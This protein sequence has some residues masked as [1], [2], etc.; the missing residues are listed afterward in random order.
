MLLLASLRPDVHTS[1]FQLMLTASGLRSGV[2]ERVD[3]LIPMLPYARSDRTEVASAAIGRDVFLAAIVGAGVDRVW[4][5]DAHIS[6]QQQTPPHLVSLPTYEILTAAVLRYHPT[7]QTIVLP[8]RGAADRLGLGVVGT[9]VIVLDKQRLSDS[10]VEV[11]PHSD[12]TPSGLTVIIDDALFTGA[13]HAA[14]ATLVRR[15][16]SGDVH[17]AVTHALPDGGAMA[18]LERAGVKSVL[19]LGTSS[20]PVAHA[21]LTIRLVRWSEQ[22]GIRSATA[23]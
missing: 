11:S 9:R 3:L 12:T 21:H 18:R 4:T 2:W 8:D 10:E 23:G 13:T 1:L 6:T 7:V 15:L 5:L 14:A 22:L 19:H 20:V 17:L 16:G